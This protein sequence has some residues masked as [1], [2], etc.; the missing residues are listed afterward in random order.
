M[1]GIF[2][3]LECQRDTVPQ[4]LKWY[5]ASTTKM[6]ALSMD[7]CLILQLIWSQSVAGPSFSAIDGSPTGQTL[8]ESLPAVPVVPR[9]PTRTF[10]FVITISLCE[11]GA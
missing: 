8:D 6:L 9:I 10:R 1:D 3:K 7:K 11:A 5:R 2:G 4:G